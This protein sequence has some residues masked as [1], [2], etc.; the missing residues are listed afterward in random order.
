MRPAQDG[1]DASANVGSPSPGRRNFL[2]AG[3]AAVLGACRKKPA[4]A[5]PETLT[6]ALE[7]GRDRYGVPAL[8]AVVLRS[9]AIVN[10]GASGLLRR[11]R[12]ERVNSNCQFHL[13]S[14]TK[15]ITA[16]MMATLVEEGR[17]RSHTTPPDVFPEWRSTIH[18][19]YRGITVNDLFRHHAGLPPFN[20][21]LSLDWLALPASKPPNE[22]ACWILHRPPARKPGTTGVYSN[23]GPSIAAAMA[24]RLTGQ[25]WEALMRARVFVPLGIR[26]GFGPPRDGDPSQPSG[27]LSTWFGPVAMN[28]HLPRFFG[29]AGNVHMNMGEY[30]RFLQV[31]L[32]GLQ[33]RNTILKADTIRH[34]H[35]PV[36][37]FGLGWGVRSIDGLMASG[38]D[39][40]DGTFYLTAR[41]WHTRDLAIAVAANVGGGRGA[42]A[43]H[44]TF[45]ALA[46]RFL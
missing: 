28:S 34:L 26:G 10:I 4:Y 23:A 7:Q 11:G 35:T 43:C 27:H 15:A 31:H 42:D 38:H 9:N 30:A 41:L 14:N 13:G 8:A 39:G 46:H 12:P 2:L 37:I 36:G 44:A 1:C 22:V 20:N 18:P 29:P 19:D 5:P 45:S 17:L 21:M 25:S 32:R 24:E 6:A 33:G 3:A 40:S 16:T